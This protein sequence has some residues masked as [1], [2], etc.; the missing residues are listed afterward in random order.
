MF[1]SLIK[2]A[3]LPSD[4]KV[5][6]GH[7][8]TR[9]NLEFCLKYEPNNEM[10][11]KKKD[12]INLRI[13]SGLPTIPFSIKDELSTNIFLR[14]KEQEVKNA[15]NLNNAPEQEI[16]AKLRDLKDNF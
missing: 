5:Y 16:F 6:C 15:L 9:K 1:H 3:C 10:L 14:C 7:E 8:Y 2:L 13:K 12:W 4:T 11:K